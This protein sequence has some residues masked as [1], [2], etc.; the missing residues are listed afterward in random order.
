M[1]M[2]AIAGGGDETPWSGGRAQQ[3]EV[4]A[5]EGG[6]GSPQSSPE[7]GEEHIGD[8]NRQRRVRVRVSTER[9]ES[10]GAAGLGRAGSV[11]PTWVD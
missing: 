11:K 10:E 8:A 4:D 2:A 5:P 3:G 9:G 1:A 6:G 7:P